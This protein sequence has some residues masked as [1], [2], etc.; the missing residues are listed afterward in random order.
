MCMPPNF[1]EMLFCI[2]LNCTSIVNTNL[3][4]TNYDIAVLEIKNCQNKNHLKMY[5]TVV[6]T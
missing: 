5:L 1:I 6:K 3:K 4:I 2:F